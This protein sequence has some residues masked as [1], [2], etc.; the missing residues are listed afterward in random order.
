[1]FVPQSICDILWSGLDY[2]FHQSIKHLDPSRSREDYEEYWYV[3]EQCAPDGQDLECLIG[4]LVELSDD[5]DWVTPS[6]V[7]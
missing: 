4:E 1:M 3:L 7:L 2:E 6:L 5:C